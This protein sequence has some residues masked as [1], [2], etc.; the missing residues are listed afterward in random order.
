M[1]LISIAHTQ[2]AGN[3]YWGK[4]YGVDVIVDTSKGYINATLLCE[5]MSTGSSS[6]SEWKQRDESAAL[7]DAVAEDTG[8]PLESIVVLYCGFTVEIQGEYVHPKLV[9]HIAAWASA[10][11][12]LYVS[13]AVNNRIVHDYKKAIAD[14]EEKI[15]EL[16]KQIAD[17]SALLAKFQEKRLRL[18]SPPAGDQ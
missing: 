16:T 9:P 6:F 1:D 17:Q 8:K 3:Y 15:A 14:Q 5:I 12:S 4:Y 7:I 13:D 18:T 10:E 11:F 2:I